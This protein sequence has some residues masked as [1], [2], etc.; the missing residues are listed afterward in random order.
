M[1]VSDLAALAVRNLA[2]KPFDLQK[3]AVGVLNSTAFIFK[4]FQKLAITY[5]LP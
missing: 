2:S 3:K 4:A 5:S 1:G